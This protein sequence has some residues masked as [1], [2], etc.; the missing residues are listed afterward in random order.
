[1]NRCRKEENI[2]ECH[3]INC[4]LGDRIH[5]AAS[6]HSRQPY[7]SAQTSQ[8]ERGVDPPTTTPANPPDQSLALVLFAKISEGFLE[9]ARLVLS[10][11][12]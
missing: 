7:P 11:V 1:M 2:Q 10:V 9:D 3:P 6:F 4:A 12:I 8:K 5:R